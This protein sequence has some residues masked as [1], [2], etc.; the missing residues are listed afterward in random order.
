MW[1][2][3]TVIML[4]FGEQASISGCMMNGLTE[5]FY[6]MRDRTSVPFF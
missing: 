4:V 3:G 2:L 5:G 1:L 6:M